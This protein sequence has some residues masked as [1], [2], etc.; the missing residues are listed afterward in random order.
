LDPSRARE[1]IA[2]AAAGALLSPQDLQAI[3]NLR[4]S[5]FYELESAGAFDQ[6]RVHP[7]I[8]NRV[9]SGALITRYLHGDP[10]YQTFAR[11]RA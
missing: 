3:F 1:A 10:V 11:R 8:G 7:P 9:Y 6:F 4:R 5:R 2:L